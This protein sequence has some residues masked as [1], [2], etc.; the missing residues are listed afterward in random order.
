MGRGAVVG[1]ERQ[2]LFLLLSYWFFLNNGCST[3]I[4]MSV[5][6]RAFQLALY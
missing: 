2:R 4:R 6:G 1:T 5:L 3:P